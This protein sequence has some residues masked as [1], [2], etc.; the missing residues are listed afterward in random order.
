MKKYIKPVM[1]LYEVEL[2]NSMLLGDSKA[3]TKFKDEYLDEELDF[4]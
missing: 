3:S 1:D 4:D 2:E